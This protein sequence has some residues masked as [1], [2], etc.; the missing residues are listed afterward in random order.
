MTIFVKNIYS[1][2]QFFLIWQLENL[3]FLF[4]FYYADRF[5]LSQGGFEFRAPYPTIPP[6]WSALS[7]RNPF[8]HIIPPTWSAFKS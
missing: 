8:L 4:L 6:T 5:N 3:F 7:P 1:A 2:I